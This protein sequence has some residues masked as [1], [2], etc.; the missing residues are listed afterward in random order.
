MNQTPLKKALFIDRDGVLI[1]DTGYPHKISDLKLKTEIFPFLKKMQSAGFLLFIMTNQSG[2]GRGYFSEEDYH[3]F[4]KELLLRL[5]NERIY[6]T[7]TY[8][9]P[10]F[11]N[12]QEKRYQK[13]AENRKPR[14]GMFLQAAQEYQLDLSQS[15]MVGD[16]L[17]DVIELPELRCFLIQGEEEKDFI[18]QSTRFY[19]NYQE[20]YEA[21]LRE[22][23]EQKEK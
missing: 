7:K 20:I 22:I 13:G 18:H 15:L 5:K 12:S 9:C 19:N 8:F 2:I 4:Q 3:I 1:E 16:K 6:I 10:Y 23:P 21:F 17:S 11:E 14:P